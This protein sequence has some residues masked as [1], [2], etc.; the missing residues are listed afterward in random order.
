[1]ALYRFVILTLKNSLGHVSLASNSSFFTSVCTVNFFLKSVY[2]CI[3]NYLLHTVDPDLFWCKL[4]IK[5]K[6]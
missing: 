3:Y 4:C 2:T 1:M 6:A 5:I